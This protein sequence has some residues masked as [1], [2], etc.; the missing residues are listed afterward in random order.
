MSFV[1]LNVWVEMPHL[2]NSEPFDIRTILPLSLAKAI[3]NIPPNLA[4]MDEPALVEAVKP[5]QT[6]WKLRIRLWQEFRKVTQEIKGVQIRKIR[7][8]VVCQNIVAYN[9][10]IRIVGNPNKAAFILRPI[11]D[12]EKETE[13]MLQIASSRLYEILTMNIVNPKTGLVNN[14]LG[15][16]LLRAVG[17]VADR[18]RGLAVARSQTVN[19]NVNKDEK[20]LHVGTTT[21][22]LQLRIKEVEAQL[23]GRE[24]IIEVE[25][26]DEVESGS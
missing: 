20:A 2:S 22:D 15:D 19:V 12:F 6:D 25:G 7:G 13:F 24:D 8:D 23:A 21:K 1:N 11:E 16:L 3:D 5:T 26:S 14:R 9:Q 10:F 17:M 4:E 18:A